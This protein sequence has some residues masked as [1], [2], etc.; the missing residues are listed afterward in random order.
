[1]HSIPPDTD[2]DSRWINLIS[3]ILHLAAGHS[4]SN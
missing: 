4:L 2:Y 3:V 1:V